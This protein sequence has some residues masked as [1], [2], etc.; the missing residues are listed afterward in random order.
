MEETPTITTQQTLFTN[1]PLIVETIPNLKKIKS[2][3][4]IEL[5]N[6]KYK[7]MLMNGNML[8]ESKQSDNL[9]NLEKFLEDDKNNNQNEPWSKLDKTVKTKKLFA[10]AEIYSK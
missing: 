7:T 9:S 8:K 6:I 2:D 3:E 1:V 5:R 10:F 4:C